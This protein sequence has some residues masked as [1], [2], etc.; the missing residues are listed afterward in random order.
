[1]AWRPAWAMLTI[2]GPNIGQIAIR[3]FANLM[4]A[5]TVQGVVS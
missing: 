3:A 1:M 4:F 5:R 2:T